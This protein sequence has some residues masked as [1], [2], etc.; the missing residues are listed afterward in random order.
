MSQLVTSAVDPLSR[1]VKYL[2]FSYFEPQ[3][4]WNMSSITRQMREL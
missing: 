4:S 2:E 3:K 1:I